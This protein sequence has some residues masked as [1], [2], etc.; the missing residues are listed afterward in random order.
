LRVSCDR[1]YQSNEETKNGSVYPSGDLGAPNVIHLFLLLSEV[2]DLK[3]HVGIV[4][5]CGG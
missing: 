4:F 1:E 5:S 2:F 3:L